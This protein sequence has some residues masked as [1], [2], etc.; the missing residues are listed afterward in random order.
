MRNMMNYEDV[1][2]IATS[3]YPSTVLPTNPRLSGGPPFSLPPPTATPVSRFVVIWNPVPTDEVY[4]LGGPSS[5]DVLHVNGNMVMFNIDVLTD[6]SEGVIIIN[7]SSQCT[8][9]TTN[10]ERRKVTMSQ[11]KGRAET[12]PRAP[13]CGCRSQMD[14]RYTLLW[15]GPTIKVTLIRTVHRTNRV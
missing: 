3:M 14:R 6:S 15:A 12:S 13:H 2:I 9:L 4:Y 8:V 10:T 11:I 5:L 1:I 7:G